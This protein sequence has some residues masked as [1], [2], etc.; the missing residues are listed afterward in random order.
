M[1][2]E[3]GEVVE[4]MRLRLLGLLSLFEL[5]SSDLR[6]DCLRLGRHRLPL[7]TCEL[8]HLS[9]AHLGAVRLVETELG[10]EE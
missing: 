2:E 9:S 4:F 1:K 10:L 8:G 5:L 7:S 6:P 3:G